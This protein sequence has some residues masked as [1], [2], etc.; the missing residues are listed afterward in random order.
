MA[1]LERSGICCLVHVEVAHVL[2][3]VILIGL[4]LGLGLR[5]PPVALEVTRLTPTV[6]LTA[7][8]LEVGLAGLRAAVVIATVTSGSSRERE[9]RAT[10]ASASTAATDSHALAAAV[11]TATTTASRLFGRGVSAGASI[12]VTGAA[13]RA[14]DGE[15]EARSLSLLF[16]QLGSLLRLGKG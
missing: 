12:A 6:S 10:A 3:L 14:R 2:S 9:G 7:T 13:S 15:L 16:R 1:G 11:S 5:L 8:A 4:L